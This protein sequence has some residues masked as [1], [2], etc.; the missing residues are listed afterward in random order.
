MAATET[1]EAP[2]NKKGFD[3]TA[4]HATIIVAIITGAATAGG[5]IFTARENLN[6][7]KQKQE[8]ARTLAQREFET[9]LIFDAI[10]GSDPKES[11]RNLKFFLE[12]GFLTESSYKIRNL[13]ESDYPSKN[14]PSFDCGEDKADV[15]Q[16][17]CNDPDL[18]V[19]DKVMAELY[20]KLLPDTPGLKKEQQSW[21]NERN[22]CIAAG[23]NVVR[24]MIDKYDIRIG[25]LKEI[26]T[27]DASAPAPSPASEAAVT[28]IK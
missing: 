7:E 1:T 15:A 5:A 17:I 8:A 12:A 19:K 23:G 24:C 6:A 20:Y 3:F 2:A 4:T 14:R 25:Q 21:I 10:K 9:K 16:V 13:S 18:A 22:R 11:I 27:R 28:P 26:A